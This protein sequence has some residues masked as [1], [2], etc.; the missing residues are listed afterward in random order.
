MKWLSVEISLLRALSIIVVSLFCVTGGGTYLVKKK[1]N[2][3]PIVYIDSIVQTSLQKGALKTTYLAELMGL[4]IDKPQTVHTFNV[5]EARESLLKSHIIKEATVELFPP[6]TVYVDYTI[7]QPIAL[8]GN[9]E[10]IA[11]DEEGALFPFHPFFPPKKLPLIY[12]KEFFP[13]SKKDLNLALTL[14]KSITDKLPIIRIDLSRL[15]AK[16]FGRQEIVILTEEEVIRDDNHYIFPILLRLTKKNYAKE[17]GAYLELR[18]RLLDEG[19][20]ALTPAMPSCHF[21]MKIIDLRVQN[22]AFITGK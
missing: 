17:L 8:L 18:E 21:P 7:R 6:Y 19:C 22:L 10:N 2:R 9:Y 1:Q 11:F 4:S 20:A 16:S 5:T 14:L 13:V 12:F 15:E 3:P